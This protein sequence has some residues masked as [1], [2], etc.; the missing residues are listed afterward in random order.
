MGTRSS[1]WASTQARAELC[2]PDALLPGDLGH[3]GGQLQVGVEVLAGEA[4]SAATEV[5]LVELVGRREAARQEAAPERRVGHEADP[6]LAACRQHPVALGIA[7][8]HGEV[9]HIR[10][11]VATR[12]VGE[13]SFRTPACK[14]A[15]TRCVDCRI[16]RPDREKPPAVIDARGCS[17]AKLRYR[18]NYSE[19]K[20][21]AAPSE[22]RRDATK[23]EIL[24]A[25]S[26]DLS[27]FCHTNTLAEWAGLIPS[28]VGDFDRSKCLKY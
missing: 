11:R 8:P 12:S 27:P 22:T 2:G 7:R 10:L 1:P 18:K 5:L 20:R 24:P 16:G 15:V 23:G 19:A 13:C 3:L 4:R 17:A 21:Q 26:R 28:C 25:L 9:D 6:E 14:A